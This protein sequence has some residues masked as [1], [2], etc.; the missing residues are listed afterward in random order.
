MI[1]EAKINSYFE[2]APQCQSIQNDKDL[3]WHKLNPTI[4]YEL[5]TLT[6]RLETT[7]IERDLC[8]TSENEQRH[9]RVDI[10]DFPCFYRESSNRDTVHEVQNSKAV[11]NIRTMLY[12]FKIKLEWK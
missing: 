11:K 6:D 1:E 4:A 10:K 5:K 3:M 12:E 2:L 9:C 8:L 7:I